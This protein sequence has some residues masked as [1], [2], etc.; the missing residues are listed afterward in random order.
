MSALSVIGR[1]DNAPLRRML[2]LAKP[3]RGT[4]VVAVLA[5]VMSVGCAVGLL[6]LSGYLIALAS[7]H[8]NEAALAVAVVGVRAF[9]LGRGVFR[10]LERLFTHEAAFRVLADLRVAVYVRLERIAGPGLSQLR[11]A[12][13]LTRLVSDVDGVQDVFIR[14]VTPPLV[15]FGVGAA[16]SVAATAIFVP[17]GLVIAGGLLAAGLVLPTV[18]AL[19]ARRADE[20]L[21]PARGLLITQAGDVVAGG[22]ELIA[23]GAV[24]SALAEFDAADRAVSRL[25]RRSAVASAFGTGASSVVVGTTVW[26]TLVLAVAAQHSGHL[27]RVG[28]AAVVLTA[29]AAFEATGPLCAAA[30]QL[31]SARGS[32]RRLFEVLDLPALVAE[33][34]SPLPVPRGPVHLRVID[35]RMRYADGGPL[36]LD[37][38]DLD[39]P[40]GRHVAVVG[41]SGAGKSSLVTALLRFRE[42]D[43]GSITLNGQ[44]IEQFASD[45][46]RRIISGCLA[47]PHL[48]D[49]TIRENIR[50][51]KPTAS[52]AE[53]DDVAE[54]MR[55]LNW[56]RELPLGW[57]TP[58]GSH[59][60]NLS[61]GQRQRIA[62]A[63][64]LLAAPQVLVLDEPTAHLD[65]AT[66]AVLMEDLERATQGQTLL[67]ITHDARQIADFDYVLTLE[68]GRM[69]SAPG[70]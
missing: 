66:A 8:P 6:G 42:L 47:D 48:F 60:C 18:S 9:G 5:G 12:D 4:L 17:G 65:E 27:G 22:A 67:L 54:R 69:V 39:L 26:L 37:G 11:G 10:Y 49:S 44:P 43:S 19:L 59:G 13:L 63:R 56:I 16:A 7:Q 25:S 46:V 50:L 53:L 2:S 33:P 15:A 52:V 1:T 41:R 36:A 61:G 58:V 40:P 45:D 51:A 30:Q 32:A 21:A 62:L 3:L 68:N 38:I 20:P 23:F 28:L 57:D 31:G 34:D 29:L 55:L 64:A 35:A 70:R 14:G 24:S